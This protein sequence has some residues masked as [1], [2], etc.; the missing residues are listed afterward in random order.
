MDEAGAE[1]VRIF[2]LRAHHLD[3]AYPAADA[4]ALVGACGMQNSPPG[5]WEAALANRAPSL[6]AEG[7]ARLLAPGG[8][9]VQAWSLRGAPYVF[10]E[11]EAGTFLSA[12]VPEQGEPWIYTD[13]IH[14]ALDALEL[15][16]DELLG[17]QRS[18][19]GRLD[20]LVVEGKPKLDRLVAS[21]MEPS[22]PA[23][24]REAWR[25]PSMYGRPDVQTVGGA[26]A[27]FL[28]R[29]CSFEGLVA[30]GER[31]GQTPTFTSFRSWTGRALEPPPDASA[32]LVRKFLR[33]FGPATPAMLASQLG[34]SGA[35]ARRMWAQVAD[36]LAPVEVLGKRA[37]VLGSDLEGL[38]HPEPLERE[39]LLLGP[40]DPYLDQRDRAVLLADKARQ[41]R[42]W[43]TA[44]NPGA[45]VHRGA[46]VGL[47]KA[48][49][50]GGR[51]EVE[52]ELWEAAPNDAA[53]RE[54]AEGHAALR[55]LELADIKVLRS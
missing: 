53:L 38:M 55:G 10:P 7:A 31:R 4:L 48:R 29:P 19:M 50:R 18:V 1:Q 26:V 8:G 6:G 12:L 34:C 44:S 16:F 30:F 11:A 15:G 36:E 23:G 14:L 17:V 9:L 5:A 25:A 45:V 47:W 52:A 43:T 40:H 54:L 22:I 21:W 24:K 3:R 39:T 37:F 42:V 28:L 32:Q 20:G 49:K 46:V 27:S 35:Q 13:G 41:R 51:L 2:R 33:C